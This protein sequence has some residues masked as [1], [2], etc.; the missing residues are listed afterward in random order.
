MG[1]E[2][3]YQLVL[4]PAPISDPLPHPS[5]LAEAEAGE[6]QGPLTPRGKLGAKL[7][8]C[9]P[10]TWERNV[11]ASRLWWDR[12]VSRDSGCSSHCFRGEGRSQ[13]PRD[14][15]GPV[16]VLED[17]ERLLILSVNLYG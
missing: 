17:L 1:R 7:D 15:E 5:C 13:S 6:P 4:F 16:R 3:L 14:P 9:L 10:L 2:G 12:V 11:R 8:V